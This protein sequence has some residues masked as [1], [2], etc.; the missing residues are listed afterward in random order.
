MSMKVTMLSASQ[1]LKVFKPIIERVAVDVVD[2]IGPT[3]GILRDWSVRLHPDNP[4]LLDPPDPRPV[5]SCILVGPG[6]AYLPAP[7]VLPEPR[8]VPALFVL[9][10][11]VA[12]IGY[13]DLGR[14]FGSARGVI[15]ADLF[16]F[17]GVLIATSLT[18]AE[19]SAPSRSTNVATGVRL[20]A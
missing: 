2:V 6:E 16:A 15:G 17:G 12:A 19:L 10:I 9:T 20:A 14:D 3:A 13:A 18:G 8:I 4:G 5:K 7:V 1:A 11:I